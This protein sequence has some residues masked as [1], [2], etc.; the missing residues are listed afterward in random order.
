MTV[1]CLHM[2]PI[3]LINLF[4]V[5]EHDNSKSHYSETND[6]EYPYV[7]TL[8]SHN[9]CVVKYVDYY[10]FDGDYICI[11]SVLPAIGMCTVHHG[12]FAVQHNVII[13]Q[14]KNKY[15]HLTDCLS[16]LAGNLTQY[17]HLK[18]IKYFRITEQQIQ[19]EFIP[20]IS[21]IQDLNNLHKMIIDAEGL[22][23]C[24]NF[25]SEGC[26][27]VNKFYNPSIIGLKKF[28]ISELFNYYSKGKINSLA[29]SPAGIYPCI[30]CSAQNNG[31]AK[32]ISTYD[33]D[34]DII[35]T[36]LITVPGDGDIYKCFVQLGKFSAQTSVHVLQPKH[37]EM[38]KSAVMISYIMSLKF[39]D[40]TYEY[41]KG[42][43]NKDRLLKEVIS[44]PVVVKGL[45][46]KQEQQI[47]NKEITINEL[48]DNFT[49]DKFKYELNPNLINWFCYKYFI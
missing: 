29:K 24:F 42:K 1:D 39:G 26:D 21:F 49:S 23:Y 47:N 3:K 7:G 17:L 8:Y 12:K 10:D 16:C 37:K 25:W 36:S 13:L 15:K 18:Y 44:L 30:S 14:L 31:I 20:R 2:K 4:N 34:T 33:F 28:L 27:D 5:I 11:S 40:G 46:Q 32:Y 41:H 9:N 22:K 19:N 35:G 45:T 48:T 38:Y 43:L 6:G